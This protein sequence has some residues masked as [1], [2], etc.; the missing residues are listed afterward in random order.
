MGQ[1]VFCFTWNLFPLNVT[2]MQK[3]QVSASKQNKGGGAQGSING[4][5][6]LSRTVKPSGLVWERN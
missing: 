2:E 3:V 6:L 1:N 4:P 5:N